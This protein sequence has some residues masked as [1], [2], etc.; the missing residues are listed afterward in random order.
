MSDDLDSDREYHED[1]SAW[2]EARNEHEAYVLA[3]DAREE[4][5][6][7]A[8]RAAALA[9]PG[10]EAAA[11]LGV[12]LLK[13]Y[14]CSS[15]S[16]EERASRCWYWISNDADE[17]VRAYSCSRAC[18]EKSLQERNEEGDEINEPERD[19]ADYDAEAAEWAD[20]WKAV[21]SGWADFCA[22]VPSG[23]HRCPRCR[24]V[25]ERVVYCASCAA[26]NGCESP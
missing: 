15:L 11:R 2:E 5:R 19:A 12:E 7:E 4:R 14:A 3:Y 13:C 10:V 17:Y 8:Y 16:H 18:I 20:F 9:L 21:P 25:D 23:H 6:Q 1:D 26:H 22:R 24:L